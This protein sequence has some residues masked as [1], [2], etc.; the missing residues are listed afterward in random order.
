MYSQT[1]RT[2]IRSYGGNNSDYGTSL[3]RNN[4]GSI[5]FSQIVA[6]NPDVP[7]A[8]VKTDAYGQ[9]IWSKIFSIRDI[10]IIKKI[11]KFSNGYVM[12][13]TSWDMSSSELHINLIR[14]D[15]AGNILWVRDYLSSAADN[16]AGLSVGENNFYIT[17]TSDYNVGSVYPKVLWM[18]TDTL[19]YME[20][21]KTFSASY[22]LTAKASELSYEEKTGIVCESNSYGTGS[23]FFN[24]AVLIVVD[25]TGNL[26]FSKSVGSYYDDEI[27]DITIDGTDWLFSGRTYFL[28]RE[29]DMSLFRMNQN[30][31]LLQSAFYD[32]STTD[33]ECTRAMINVNHQTILTGDAGTFDERNIYTAKADA[34][35]DIIWAVQYPVSPFFTNY[36]FDIVSIPAD[37]GYIITSDLRPPSSF[38]N[39]GLFRTNS[40]G[41]I[42]CHDSPIT[43]TKYTDTQEIIDAPVTITDPLVINLPVTAQIL[44]LPFFENTICDAFASEFSFVIDTACPLLCVNFTDES[45]NAQS[46]HWEFPG[47]TPA[48]SNLQQPPPICYDAPESF[49]VTLTTTNYADTLTV[50]HV[51][52]PENYCDEIII[53]NI[54]TPNGDNLNDL[55]TI[56]N[57]RGNFSLSIFNRWGNKIFESDDLHKKWPVEKINDG[58]YY[59]M[60]TVNN[61][62]LRNFNGTVTVIK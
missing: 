7:S 62:Q 35:G 34:N 22:N 16:A 3:L 25:S 58:V 4:D 6:N 51:V 38:R 32:A 45:V 10:N 30:G 57:L 8:I 37:S 5:V 1:E 29:W 43:F 60:L 17:A 27:S 55:F 12:L 2:F 56:K 59:F 20:R 24:N 41:N 19:G 50:T 21:S 23:F 36:P 33:G 44:P 26:V 52:S 49:T 53:P 39:A 14:T 40:T 46:W 9:L 15:S 18:K 48:F 13:G 47:G 11:V 31:V 54:V 28:N 61:G 42:K